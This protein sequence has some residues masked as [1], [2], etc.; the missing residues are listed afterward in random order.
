MTNII[1][2]RGAACRRV[3]L[4][5]VRLVWEMLQRSCGQFEALRSWL[6]EVS[7]PLLLRRFFPLALDGLGAIKK[8][9][10]HTPRSELRSHAKAKLF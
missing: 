1:R 8:K 2:P 3:Y 10:N 7:F 9:K 4:L 5:K 6:P